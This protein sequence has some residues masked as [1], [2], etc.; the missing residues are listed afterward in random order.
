MQLFSIK[1]YLEKYKKKLSHEDDKRD[2]LL[3]IINGET[4]I[5]LDE[6]TMTIVKGVITIKAS[7]VVKNEL[8]LHKAQIIKQIRES[9]RGDIIDIS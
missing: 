5:L 1:E 2:S 8:F 7:A 6:K 4:G 3:N 9:G